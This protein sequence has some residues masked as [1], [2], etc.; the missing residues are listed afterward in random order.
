MTDQY[1][2]I[3]QTKLA[4]KFLQPNTLNYA[5]NVPNSSFRQGVSTFSQMPPPLVHNNTNKNY[6]YPTYN[7]SM[8]INNHTAMYQG[9]NGQNMN[10][11]M[12]TYGAAYSSDD[13]Q[14]QMMMMRQHDL[15]QLRLQQQAALQQ[16][17]NFRQIQQERAQLAQ[18]YGGAHYTHTTTAYGNTMMPGSMHMSSQ[19][20][21]NPSMMQPVK[22]VKMEQR[23]IFPNLDSGSEYH[24]SLSNSLSLDN[25]EAQT[26]I[27]DN[28][29]KN[30]KT[31]SIV[32]RRGSQ[33]IAVRSQ[34][35]EKRLKPPKSV[36]VAEFRRPL[37]A[38]N[39]FFSVERDY[40]L[41]ILDR[42]PDSELSLEPKTLESSS[43]KTVVTEAETE[44]LTHSNVETSS[45]VSIPSEDDYVLHLQDLIS[46][47]EFS[48]KELADIEENAK[49]K[50]KLLLDVHME[51]DRVKKPHRKTHGKIG[52]KTLGKLIGLRWRNIDPERRSYFEKIAKQDIERFNFQVQT[53]TATYPH[54]A[55]AQYGATHLGI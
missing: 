1:R 26:Q 2:D 38:Y 7:S 25:S 8:G 3:Q 28:I 4:V 49:L 6:E 40:I 21:H 33:Q 53:A 45:M 36:L 17:Y 34:T 18:A 15:T 39:F 12:M 46:K 24:T 32:I 52:F 5:P 35:E 27:T 42:I 43:A 13:W 14:N 50:T 10:P 22:R 54:S 31:P 41:K 48:P 11:N 16:D 55:D 37:T 51:A 19:M 47:V 29:S 44:S 20:F 9:Y 30:H 23:Y